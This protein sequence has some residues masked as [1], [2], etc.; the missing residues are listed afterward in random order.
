[1]ASKLDVEVSLIDKF[2]AGLKAIKK[3][4]DGMAGVFKGLAGAGTLALGGLTLGIKESVAAAAEAET[5]Q[6]RLAHILK[7]ATSATDEQIQALIK[8][9]GAL[10]NIGVVSDDVTQA[11]QGTLATFDLQAESIEALIPAFLDMMVAEKGVNATTDDA[12]GLANG[13]GKVLQGQVGAL[14]KQGF[15]FDENTEKILKNGTEMEKVTALAG[16]L[17]STYGGLNESLRK[18]TEGGFKGIEIAIDEMKEAIGGILLPTINSLMAAIT[19]LLTEITAWIQANPEL[20]QQILIITA[21]IAGLMVAVGL[22]GLAL[23]PIITGITGLGA[24]IGLALSPIGL[25]TA[26]ILAVGAAVIYLWNTNEEFRN[27]V[28]TVWGQISV[29]IGN[30]FTNITNWVNNAV[31]LFQNWIAE[32]QSTID[33]IL[34]VWQNFQILFSQTF[35]LIAAV[36]TALGTAIYNFLTTNQTVKDLLILLWEGFK[37]A[38][39][40]IYLALGTTINTFLD[41]LNSIFTTGQVVV[42]L[43]TGVFTQFQIG[44]EILWVD[45]GGAV[46]SMTTSIIG[47]IDGVVAKIGSAIGILQNFA[48]EAAKIAANMVLPGLGNSLAAAGSGPKMRANGGS[49]LAGETYVVGEQGPEILNMGG[50]AGNIVPNRKLK[51]GSGNITI[52]LNVPNFVDKRGLEKMLDEVVIG[53]LRKN[54]IPS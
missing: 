11:A 18:T 9:S 35:D 4:V 22:F 24:A 51:G 33:K 21:G 6:T 14:S 13:L 46:S 16:I 42:A 54:L 37:S 17:S 29:T 41:V 32:N 28:I 23:A 1:M 10:Q 27:N 38:F 53:K 44:W 50:R 15:I 36:V 34:I 26:G 7:T 45:I 39:N 31:A 48:R 25:M 20:T 12:I 47:W 40:T 2:T 43:L 8:Q 5:A 52:V 19:P 3:D 30:V 49:V